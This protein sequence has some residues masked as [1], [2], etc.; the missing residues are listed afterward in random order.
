M[1]ADSLGGRRAAVRLLE[2]FGQCAVFLAAIGVYAIAAF[3]AAARRREMA[4][5]AAFGASA[6]DLLSLAI[7][8][9]V[10]TSAFGLLAGLLTAWLASRWLRAL[11]VFLSPSDAATYLA[12]AGVLGFVTLVGAALPAWRA[13]RVSPAEVLRT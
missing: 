10:R 3:S 6:R 1:L 9:E 13:R 2:A 12:V 7:A 8:G 5:R 4:I 11:L